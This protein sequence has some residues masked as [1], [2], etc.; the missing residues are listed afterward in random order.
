M[1]ATP[2]CLVADPF[3][4]AGAR[5]NFAVERHGPLGVNV[6]ASCGEQCQIGIVEPTCF[7]FAKTNIYGDTRTLQ[8]SGALAGDLGKRIGHRGNDTLDSGM[9]NRS[10]ARRRFALVAAWLQRDE[11]RRPAGRFAGGIQGV[12]FRMGFTKA[13]MPALPHNLAI[14]DNHCPDQ[15]VRFHITA[16]TFRQIQGTQHPGAIN[17]VHTNFLATKGIETIGFVK[18]AQKPITKE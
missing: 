17:V 13:L 12:D 6:W 7:G 10:G 2:S 9:N 4:I 11:Q 18:I 5:A 14:A 15:G 8:L 1:H 16:A 3:G